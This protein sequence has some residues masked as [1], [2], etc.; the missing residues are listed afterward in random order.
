MIQTK[1]CF[2]C[3]IDGGGGGGMR[4]HRLRKGGI[5]K[6]K[7]KEELNLW[8]KKVNQ[9]KRKKKRNAEMK[10]TQTKHESSFLLPEV[11][12]DNETMGQLSQAFLPL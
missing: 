12:H 10:P 6:Y 4:K 8:D 1:A 9:I 2:S 7:A 5:L 3:E 11:E